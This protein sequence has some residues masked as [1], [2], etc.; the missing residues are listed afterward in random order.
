MEFIIDRISD[1]IASLEDENK[2]IIQVTREILPIAA[3]AGDVIKITI[4]QEAT[5]L[6]EA[7]IK[8]L[9]EDIWAD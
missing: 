6:R 3:K 4:D 8:A 1:Q 7:K 5:C 2:R 9:M